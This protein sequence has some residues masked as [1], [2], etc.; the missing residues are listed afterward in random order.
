M[1]F[2]VDSR[3]LVMMN[4]TDYLKNEYEE[5]NILFYLLVVVFAIVFAIV[6]VIEKWNTH[7]IGRMLQ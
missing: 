5:L 3:M 4:L 7:E 6:L 2:W 1:V